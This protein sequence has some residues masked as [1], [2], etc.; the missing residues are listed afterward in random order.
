MAD[1]LEIVNSKKE[2]ME[3]SSIDTFFKS[4]CSYYPGKGF[5]IV[6]EKV[7]I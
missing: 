6:F 2:I 1:I 4:I 7:E 3:S 5:F